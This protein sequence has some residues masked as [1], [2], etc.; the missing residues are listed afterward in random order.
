[1][2]L[3]GLIIFL[4]IVGVGQSVHLKYRCMFFWSDHISFYCRG[5]SVWSPEVQVCVFIFALS[6]CYI[7][8]YIIIIRL[9]C[10]CAAVPAHEAYITHTAHPPLL[11]LYVLGDDALIS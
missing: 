1:M 2:C 4:S 11:D 10:R 9:L 3:P 6:P 8:I 7:F 5:R